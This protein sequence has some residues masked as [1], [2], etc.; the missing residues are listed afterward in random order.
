MKDSK[1]LILNL[2]TH[3]YFLGERVEFKFFRNLGLVLYL[4]MNIL[5]PYTRAACLEVA[6][7][8]QQINLSSN[9]HLLFE[10]SLIFMI[11]DNFSL[12]LEIFEFIGLHKILFVLKKGITLMLV[13]IFKAYCELKAQISVYSLLNYFSINLPLYFL[14]V[15]IIG[16]KLSLSKDWLF[17][18][19]EQIRLRIIILIASTRNPSLWIQN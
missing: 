15:F 16:D 11:L 9:F 3:F 2:P 7:V 17:Y 18:T 19:I 14:L 12:T 8:L 6:A 1:K 4:F 13:F 5:S 10:P